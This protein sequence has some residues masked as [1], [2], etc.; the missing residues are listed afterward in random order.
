VIETR[1][2]PVTRNRFMAAMSNVDQAIAAA[3]REARNKAI[4][5]QVHGAVALLLCGIAA[6]VART[7]AHHLERSVCRCWAK[8]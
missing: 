5:L 6:V 7:V 2:V 1:A 3:E 4:L 8:V